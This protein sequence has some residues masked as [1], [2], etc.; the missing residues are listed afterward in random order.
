MKAN[1]PV[2][3]EEKP[4][5]RWAYVGYATQHG[6][7][8]PGQLSRNMIERLNLNESEL[9]HKTE[10]T[11]TM[12]VWN[13]QSKTTPG[14]KAMLWSVLNEKEKAFFSE[15]NQTFGVQLTNARIL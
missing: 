6:L 1:K 5:M 14:L 13:T 4:I 15:L 9:T 8:H 2:H 11:S 3:V 7:A 12:P 10:K